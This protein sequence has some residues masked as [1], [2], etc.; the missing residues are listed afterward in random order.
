MG[1]ADVHQMFLLIYRSA[2]TKPELLTGRR[3]GLNQEELLLLLLEV[4]IVLINESGTTE[5]LEHGPEPEQMLFQFVQLKVV[6]LLRS[7]W[8]L[9]VAVAP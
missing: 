7:W 3:R 8:V 5:P 1:P 4:L 6:E 9:G 2:G